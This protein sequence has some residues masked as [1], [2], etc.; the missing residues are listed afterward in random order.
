MT[1]ILRIENLSLEV[2]GKKI[3]DGL[4]LVIHENEKAILFGQNGAGKSS[5]LYAI[6]GFPGYKVTSGK[7]IFQGQEITNLPINERVKL[8]IGLA[9]QSP[10]AI[11][12]I[13]LK[14]M[15]K[16]CRSEVQDAEIA[17]LSKT[18]NM[19]P[20]LARDIN[21]GFSGGEAKRA[22]ILQILVQ[23]PAFVMFDE[24]DSGVD[25]ENIELIGNEINQYLKDHAGLI[26]THQGYILN[27]IEATR[28]CVLYDGKVVCS[29]KPKEVLEDIKT[30]GYEGCVL[31]RTQKH[32][33][34]N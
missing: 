19:D 14:E 29:G 5:L 13:K 18:F 15:L 17:A 8:G 34:E 20:F 27:F 21:L 30:K 31:C 1:E 4:H 7:I 6:M 12:G 24:P 2:G 22:E 23:R 33:A 9:F 10:P 28:A 25:L 16:V 11:R 3:L 26:I 32:E